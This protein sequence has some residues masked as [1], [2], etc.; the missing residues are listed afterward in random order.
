[1]KQTNSA[2]LYFNKA[3]TAERIAVII[4]SLLLL[5][6]I[7]ACAPVTE[8]KTTELY[9]T[10]LSVIP[11]PQEVNLTGQ[12]F[13]LG[14]EATIV[15]DQ[16]ATESDQFAAQELADQL[17]EDWGIDVTI[18]TSPGQNTIRLTRETEL[19]DAGEQDY[20]LIASGNEITI[21]A[22]G[23]P[24]L[25]YGTQTLVQLIKGDPSSA[26]IPGVEIFDSPDIEERAVHY[27]TK[28]SQ[29][30]KE[31]VRS[32]IRDLAH[33]KINMMVWEWED[34]FAYPSHPDIGA[35]GAFTME[36]MQELT[37]YAQKYHVQIVPLVQGLGHVSYILKWPQYAHLREINASNWQFC[38]MND[39]TY[40]LLYDLWED[41]I[42]ATPGS[43]YI[44]IGS[45]E[46]YE[47][48]HGKECGCHAK[49]EEIGMSGLFHEFLGRS[50][51]HLQET[52]R[53]VMAW[54]RPMGWEEH[55]SPIKDDELR[56]KELVLT[57]SYSWMSP[58]DYPE[59]TQSQELGHKVFVYDPNP[60]I[61]PLFLPYFYRESG[62][63]HVI[64]GTE[65]KKT[66]MGSL[67]NSYNTLT[68]AANS[69]VFDGMIRTSWDDAGLHNQLWM[70]HYVASAEFSWSG[71]GPSLDE[72]T[73]SYFKSYYGDDV[74]DA[75]ELFRLFNEGSYYYYSTLERK[76]WHFGTIGKTTLP[77]LPRGDALEYDPYWK[78]QYGYMID[79]SKDMHKK[80]ERALEII[81]NNV[82]N[83]VDN[84]YDFELFRA[85]AELIQHTA[86]L[87]MDLADLEDAIEEAHQNRFL[88]YATS[89]EEL[90]KAVGIAEGILDRR[91]EVYDNLVS[92]WEETTMPKGYSTDDKP[93]FFQQDRARHFA[94]R[95]PDMS[96]LIYDEELLDIEGYLDDLKEYTAWYKETYLL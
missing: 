25:Y 74:Q 15:L 60:G 90:E 85:T 29:D 81:D 16:S 70:L 96:Y 5:F 44:H 22:G 55:S 51:R 94:H 47:L 9:D 39:G 66:K 50:A 83:K 91:Q 56:A 41:A 57:E 6:V 45:D 12:E 63:A 48:G 75:E 42:E 33:Y 7:S 26:V 95:T 49:A 8:E 76:V 1:M 54:E 10:G 18:S 92:T 31:Y 20:R 43:E 40:D 46:T 11:Y 32:F 34:K 21:E 82:D 62:S 69:G 23:E 28:H 71:S 13:A 67:E 86:L 65:E 38:T 14:P 73:S 4:F 64:P 35:P 87:Y 30:K 17:N 36:E 72:F 27:D 78:A 89:Y 19:E 59:V 2:I 88:S 53:E 61:E 68:S 52:G 79:L 80:M 58:P 3:F 93:Y 77:D 24:G 84:S 37:R